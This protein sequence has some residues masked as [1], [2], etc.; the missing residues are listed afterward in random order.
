MKFPLWSRVVYW[1]LLPAAVL[2]VV[3]AVYLEATAPRGPFGE[4]EARMV[5]LNNALN[6]LLA[7]IFQVVLAV[8]FIVIGGIIWSASRLPGGPGPSR[9]LPL[10]LVTIYALSAVCAV[11]IA[12][13]T[14]SFAALLFLGIAIIALTWT[15]VVAAVRLH[16]PLTNP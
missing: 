6:L 8:F 12:R 9:L 16:R 13:G 5:L 2:L 7:E 4:G 11:L 15:A 14:P 3:N 1:A 10:S